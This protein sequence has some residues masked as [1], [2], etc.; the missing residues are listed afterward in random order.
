MKDITE[1]DTKLVTSIL[2]STPD[3]QVYF[4]VVD[5]EYIK[6]IEDDFFTFI[7]SGI[8][9]E[10]FLDV[11]NDI[12][13]NYRSKAL[14]LAS[15]EVPDD[16]EQNLASYPELRGKIYDFLA[17]EY[18]LNYYHKFY[19]IFFDPSFKLEFDDETNHAC[20][21]IIGKFFQ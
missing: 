15:I 16:F 5:P 8:D 17:Q 14:E 4:K 10:V 9:D 7:Q 12:Q 13:E 3:A 21:T 11:V 2:Q 6:K 18:M 20:D 19:T 1:N